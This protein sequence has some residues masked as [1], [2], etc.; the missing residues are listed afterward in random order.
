L[1]GNPISNTL[2]QQTIN[3]ILGCRVL[4]E[5]KQK[6]AIKKEEERKKDDNTEEKVKGKKH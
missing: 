3:K 6:Q 5:P 2:N 4:K 1:K